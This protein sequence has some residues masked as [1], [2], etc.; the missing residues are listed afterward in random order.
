MGPR[1]LWGHATFLLV[2]T[3][4]HHLRSNAN[5]YP[6]TV[7]LLENS[8]YVDDVVLGARNDEEAAQRYAE[9]QDIFRTAS[10]KLQKWGSNSKAMR[11]R[12][13]KEKDAILLPTTTE[14]LRVPWDQAN[15][16]LSLP[17]HG[18]GEGD[19]QTPNVTK[20][21]ALRKFAQI[22]DPLG[23]ILPC[24]VTGKL[25]LQSIWKRELGWATPLPS[26]LNE[27]WRDWYSQL[28]LLTDVQIPR[29][30]GMTDSEQAVAELH[31]FSDA[32]PAAYGTVVYLR[33]KDDSTGYR[34]ELLMARSRIAPIK[35]MTLARLE[36][37][38]ALMASRLSTY[39]RDNLKLKNLN[40][41]W[42]DSMITLHW[43]K[44]DPVR[45]TKFVCNRVIEIQQS[46]GKE[47]WQYVASN[48]NPADLLTRGIAPRQ[49]NSDLW[50]K[51]PSWLQVSRHTWP[52]PDSSSIAESLEVHHVVL[53]S[54]QATANPIVDVVL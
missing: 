5:P 43:I 38:G 28:T 52:S 45:W 32:S 3:L 34:T 24:T 53:Q 15:D 49:L 30:Y 37:L 8:I 47:H 21:Q 19:M 42:T 22:Y 29:Y 12:F 11:D 48:T 40:Y 31:F 26:D 35:E 44:G 6:E 14:V 17:I 33:L 25:I 2:A 9:T 46:V 50:W 54:N 7:G 4:R 39:L 10:M 1:L 51:G 16:T 41:F 36:L 23:F 27:R 20:R 13:R 18:T